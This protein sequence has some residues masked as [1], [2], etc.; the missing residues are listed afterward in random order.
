MIIDEDQRSFTLILVSIIFGTTIS[1]FA[2][3]F[4]I[5]AVEKFG[6]ITGGILSSLPITIVSTS[7]LI[8]LNEGE[9][10]H[11]DSTSSS[12]EWFQD[13]LEFQDY[14]ATFALL[15]IILSFLPW[16]F[17]PPYLPSHLHRYHL[18]ILSLLSSFLF[19]L[20]IL[21][22]IL[23]FS[24]LSLIHNSHTRHLLLFLSG[25]ISFILTLLLSF[26]CSILFPCPAPSAYLPSSFSS[27]LLHSL[28]ASLLTCLSLLLSLYSSI[29]SSVLSLTPTTIV[30]IAVMRSL[31]S[32]HGFEVVKGAVGPIMAGSASKTMY[33]MLFGIVLGSGGATGIELV[34]RIIMSGV[35]AWIGSVLGVSLP[36]WGV[37]KWRQ[38]KVDERWMGRVEFSEEEEERGT[39][40][41]KKEEEETSEV[42]R[43]NTWSTV[44]TNGSEMDMLIRKNVV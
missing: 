1:F 26:L 3:M 41:G 36:V 44:Q 40:G 29:L 13:Q 12:D 31:Y 37:L 24:L 23:L 22:S 7:M 19:L 33:L 34:K 14:S 30:Y 43:Q 17:L 5:W 9:F 39:E 16:R 8:A 38:K 25:L 21:A 4:S 15:L 6:G 20:S 35:I 18:S 2:T 42:E 11:N 32:S 28:L 27:T 10:I